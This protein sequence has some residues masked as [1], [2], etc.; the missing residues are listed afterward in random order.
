MVQV[1]W[2]EQT[3]ANVPAGNDWLTEE[4]LRFYNALRFA[5]RRSE[6]RLGRWTAKRATATF[7]KGAGRPAAVAAIELRPAPSGAPEVVVNR[8][9]VAFHVSLSHC[10]GT[11]MCAVAPVDSDVGCDVEI[12][13]QRAESFVEDYFTAGERAAV[14]GV[15]KDQ[16]PLLVTLLWSAKESVLKALRKGLTADTRDVDVVADDGRR[17][18]LDLWRPMAARCTTGEFF[19]GWWR[20]SGRL[21][22]TIVSSPAPL[23]P[24]RIEL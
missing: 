24:I 22:W 17:W 18:G 1:Y 19:R 9:P 4:E 15:A 12:V 14:R 23:P 10:C 3:E 2:L 16:R 8:E 20:D 21:V 11:A 13:E 7:L 5:K 6:W